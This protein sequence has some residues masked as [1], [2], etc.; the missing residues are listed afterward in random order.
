MFGY[1]KPYIPSLS[2]AEFEAYRGAYCGLCRT[3][4]SLTGQISRLT[5]NYDFAFLTVFRLAMEKERSDFERSHCIAHPFVKRVHM[6]RNS[7]LEYTAAASAVLTRCK[8]RD[9]I[10]DE[11]GFKRLGAKML[12]PAV[13]SMV[14][15]VRDRISELEDRKSTRL[16]SSHTDS[17]R[18]PSSA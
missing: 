13:N 16:N 5:L 14:K 11:T 8:V 4:G 9:N 12:S 10:N 3:M 15:R 2:V 6:I 17:S 7:A 18:M 1:I